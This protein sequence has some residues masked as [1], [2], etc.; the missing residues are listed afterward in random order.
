MSDPN[1]VPYAGIP[2]ACMPPGQ[3]GVVGTLGAGADR[4]L[5]RALAG[6]ARGGLSGNIVWVTKEMGKQKD[7]IWRIIIL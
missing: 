6:S 3:T 5:A 7:Q 2:Q 1:F 4:G